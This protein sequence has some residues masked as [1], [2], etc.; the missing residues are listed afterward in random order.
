MS[1]VG[2][3]Q[4]EMIKELGDIGEVKDFFEFNNKVHVRAEFVTL[5]EEL[6]SDPGFRSAHMSQG[7]AG[8]GGL[9]ESAPEEERAESSSSEMDDG[10]RKELLS[11]P[12]SGPGASMK[13]SSSKKYLGSS[14]NGDLKSYYKLQTQDIVPYYNI[15]V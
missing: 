14:S 1:F 9:N 15:L 13:K 2:V 5:E 6:R 11:H 7:S 3:P 10:E 4:E 8:N 12:A